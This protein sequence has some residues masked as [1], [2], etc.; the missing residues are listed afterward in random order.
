M[1]CKHC[2]SISREHYQ[3]EC[4]WPRGESGPCLTEER[5]WAREKNDAKDGAVMI[6][7]ILFAG[8]LFSIA[9]YLKLIKF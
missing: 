6:F 1:Y 8:A 3:T 2:G 5:L 4:R 7:G 9:T